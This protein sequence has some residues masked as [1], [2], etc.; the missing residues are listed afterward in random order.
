MVW[1]SIRFR[2][3]GLLGVVTAGLWV[4]RWRASAGFFRTL[5]IY[6]P[7]R[8]PSPQVLPNPLPAVPA[9]LASAVLASADLGTLVLGH[10]GL[11]HL[12]QPA[13]VCKALSTAA[14]AQHASRAVLR[15]DRTI[16]YRKGGGE[17]ELHSPFFVTE[18]PGGDLCVSD[19][20]NRRLQFVSPAGGSLPW[21]E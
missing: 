5:Q 3:A 17:G 1:S 19:F 2:V 13:R 18:M 11:L 12:A 6:R 10:L 15:Y 20:H 9:D 21:C 7:P 8:L 4:L 14:R 16:E